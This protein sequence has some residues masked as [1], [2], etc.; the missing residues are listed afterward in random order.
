M[1]FLKIAIDLAGELER[2]GI[3]AVFAYGA[4]VLPTTQLA[5]LLG[6]ALLFGCLVPMNLR[7]L[8][9]WPTVPLHDMARVLVRSSLVGGL[10]AIVSGVLLLSLNA[11]GYMQNEMMWWKAGFFVIALLNAL[12]LR[13]V[14]AWRYLARVDSRGTIRRFRW[15][16]LV[17]LVAWGGVMVCGALYGMKWP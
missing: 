7:M 4:W 1:D 5:H 2:S 16:G 15:A 3:R 11:R 9:V 6:A 8:G 12:L 13:F 10:V 14:P 17:A